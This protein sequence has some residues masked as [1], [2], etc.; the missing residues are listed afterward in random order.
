MKSILLVLAIFISFATTAAEPESES[1]N[2]YDGQTYIAMT[3]GIRSVVGNANQNANP[4]RKATVVLINCGEGQ[5]DL[6]KSTGLTLW[7]G[8]SIRLQ[9]NSPSGYTTYSCNY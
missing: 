7:A 5:S 1:I 4:N 2:L 6:Q 9:S 3:P 8:E